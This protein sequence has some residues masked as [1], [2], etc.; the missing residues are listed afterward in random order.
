MSSKSITVRDFRK[1]IPG[2]VD[3]ADPTY[4]RFPVV[5][6]TN[7][8]GKTTY[9]E[10]VVRVCYESP[11]KTSDADGNY[12]D[13]F[14]KITDELFDSK[15]PMPT[16]GASTA[17]AWT[18]VLSKIGENGKVKKA[19]PTYTRVGK[20][21]GRSNETNAFTQALRDAL[22]KYNKQIQKSAG[23]TFTEFDGVKLFPPMLAQV[24]ENQ[25]DVSFWKDESPKFAQLKLNGVRAVTTL[26]IINT[27][28]PI[29][30]TN[31]LMYSRT[32]KVYPGFTYLKAE[33]LPVLKFFIDKYSQR[34]YLDG[35]IYKHGVD[36][37]V[38]S[39][40]ARQELNESKQDKIKLQYHVYDVFVPEEPNMLYEDRMAILETIS[41]EFPGLQYTKIVSTD[42][43]S[44]KEEL[45][46][47]YERAL[48]DGYEG[49]MLRLNK[50]YVYSYNDYHSRVLLKCKPT[51]DAE[52]KITG[53]TAGTQ[54]KA[55]GA[56]MFE[57]EI[58]KKGGGVATL[59]INLG[60]ELPD[61]IELYK[62]M[63]TI[64]ANGKTHFENV[65]KGKLLTILYDELS[66]DGI[67]VR[68]RTNGIILRDYE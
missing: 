16:K 34:I 4:Y 51:H 67:P 60:M 32:R 50:P 18:K 58:P 59:T 9:W 40:T 1:D 65:Y 26:Q 45:D 3:L 15:T 31:T 20:N 41:D 52:Y 12:P 43:V 49:A 64:E 53:Y 14:I 8:N 10:L 44:S 24:L 23:A 13:E 37:Q 57:L 66:S 62:K 2:E 22:G 54:G 61:R 5:T 63:S 7:K 19:P 21:I 48:A 38:I 30:T 46:A 35:E 11:D 25:K 27:G 36:L 6:S 33:L 55:E 28:E 68:S 39:G 47:F 17:V 29:E 42:Y 56:L